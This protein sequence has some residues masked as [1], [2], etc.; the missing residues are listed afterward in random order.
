MDL[1][2][3]LKNRLTGLIKD[4]DGDLESDRTRLFFEAQKNDFYYRG[5][6]RVVPRSAGGTVR[7]E[8]MTMPEDGPQ[9]RE[10]TVNKIRGDGKKFASVLGQKSPAVKAV[11]DDPRSEADRSAAREYDR[12]AAILR[13]WWNV[14]NQQM[15]LALFVYKYGTTFGYTR[16]VADGERFGYREEPII[17]QI[18]IETRP[19]YY[20]CPVCGTQTPPEQMIVPPEDGEAR[21]CPTCNS[22]LGGDA[23]VPAETAMVPQVVGTKRYPNGQV[24]LSLASVLNV[25]VPFGASDLSECNYLIYER[26]ED[27]ARVLATWP[28]LRE[29]LKSGTSSSLVTS[30]VAEDARTSAVSP[31]GSTDKSKFL[32]TLTRCW[33]RPVAFEMVEDEADRELLKQSFPDGVKV[34]LVD[35]HFAAAEPER[36]DDHWAFC[37]SEP[38]ESIYAP[39]TCSG[40]IDFQDAFTDAYTIAMETLERG[41]PLSIFSPDV[42]DPNVLASRPALPAEMLPARNQAGD[43]QKAVVTIPT[44]KFPEQMPEFIGSFEESVR[45]S[46]GI[47]AEIAGGGPEGLTATEY[48]RRQNQALA[49][50]GT[51]WQYM[52]SFW[53]HVYANGVKELANYAVGELIVP[54]TSSAPGAT[55]E[56]LNLEALKAGNAHFDSDEAI[57]QNLGMQREQLQNLLTQTPPPVIDALG[58]FHPDNIGGIRDLLGL[59]LLKV[60]GEDQRNKIHETISVLLAESATRDEV[61]NLIPSIMP[62]D[63]EDDMG[64][65]LD[66][67]RS[68]MASPVG[69][70]QKNSNPKG[71]ENV[72]AYALAAKMLMG[73]PPPAPG[74][75]VPPAGPPPKAGPPP[76]PA[77]P[78]PA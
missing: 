11:P 69:R 37:L 50:L 74:E 21:I 5:I 4:F 17:E 68:W 13:N 45:D 52:R 2:D 39:A 36:M 28:H 57:P 35:G 41:L 59:P 40:S 22:P 56:S 14:G 71:Y 43:L 60:P 10:Y 18:E 23:L 24:C 3:D 30:K 66:V 25:R 58:V 54:M 1:N 31:S 65:I 47:R 51:Q 78:A 46:N 62:D 38:S 72:K 48:V 49:Q 7:L 67:V 8:P 76:V 15:K 29:K 33:L 34:S 6:Q 9:I 77:A 20:D 19:A 63:I 61:G 53:T 27:Q 44:A 55:A 73:P 64:M 70:S 75:E 32:V 12:A 42:I 16:W 26:E